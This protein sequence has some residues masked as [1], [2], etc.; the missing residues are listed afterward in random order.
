MTDGYDNTNR[1][2]LWFK[3]RDDKPVLAFKGSVD[4]GGVK[5]FADLVATRAAGEK[6]PAY[7][8]YLANPADYSYIGAPVFRA[9]AGEKRVGYA[10]VDTP[11]GSFWVSVY[12]NDRS[13]AGS[14]ALDLSAQVKEEQPHP[15]A[16]AAA[17]AA[18][19]DAADIPF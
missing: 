15:G 18:V 7:N 13:T 9:K 6:A 8:L 19:E 4:L 16:Q 1:G 11:G 14:P 17:E 5:Y 3:G 12:K 10:S 2:A